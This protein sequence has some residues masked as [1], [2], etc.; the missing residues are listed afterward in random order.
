MGRGVVAGLCEG[1]E[2]LN[3]CV[4]Y[5]LF[6]NNAGQGLLLAQSLPPSS[7]DNHAAIIYANSLPEKNAYERLGYRTSSGGA[8]RSPV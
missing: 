2:E 8:R 6:G 5:V 4:D 1:L 7:I 3:D